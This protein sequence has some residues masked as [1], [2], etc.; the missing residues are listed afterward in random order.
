MYFAFHCGYATR[1]LWFPLHLVAARVL[2]FY[3]GKGIIIF[4]G[5]RVLWFT[6]GQWYYDFHGDKGIMV[7]I[8]GK[9]SFIKG[10]S[11]V[12]WDR[13]GAWLYRFL[14]FALFL[15]LLAYHWWKGICD[16]EIHQG[17]SWHILTVTR[18]FLTYQ[19]RSVHFWL[20]FVKFYPK[21]F[22]LESMDLNA[23]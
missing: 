18:V 19:C 16:I 11:L 8:R 23:F 1:V 10:F 6:L 4:I 2:C 7:F 12:S 22:L 13:C 14:I 9:G 20:I 15:T 3:W 21:Y 5:A 17:D